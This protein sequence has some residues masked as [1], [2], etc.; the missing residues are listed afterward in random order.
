MAP[1][2]QAR[3]LRRRRLERRGPPEVGAQRPDQRRSQGRPGSAL[4]VGPSRGA[5]V[6]AVEAVK[7]EAASDDDAGRAGVAAG[8][9][10]TWSVFG[11]ELRRHQPRQGALSRRGASASTRSRSATC[12]ATRPRSR[13]PCCPTCAGRA[14]NMHRFPGGADTQGLLAQGAAQPRAGVAA[15]LGQPGGRPGRG[16]DVSRRRRA[17]GPGLGGELRRARMARLDLAASKPPDR[18]RMR[19]S[20]STRGTRPRGPTCWRWPGCTARRSSISGVVARPKVTGRRGIQI[21]VPIAAGPDLRRHPGLGRAAVQDGRG[22]RPGAGQLEVGRQRARR[23]GAAGL[24]AERDQ[25]DLGRAVQPACGARRPG[26]GADRVGRARRPVT[27]AG[28]LHDPVH[29]RPDRGEGRP[30]RRP[31]RHA[32]SCP[33]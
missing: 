13:R 17:G 8:V 21:W 12:C 15:A 33:R 1:A 26:V 22:R 4:A 7:P 27:A 3:R 20:T 29:A 11:R 24:H 32:S 16:P 25:Q 28:R 19:W 9:G 18:R 6:A 23:A 31:A 5:R 10:G 2:A 30:L 14:L